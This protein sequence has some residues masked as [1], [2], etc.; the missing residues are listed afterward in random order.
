M[1]VRLGGGATFLRRRQNIFCLRVLFTSRGSAGALARRATL[2]N[3]HYALVPSIGRV[4]LGDSAHVMFAQATVD[5]PADVVSDLWQSIGSI[6]ETER[7]A[8][9][10]PVG[11]KLR[12][13]SH[14]GA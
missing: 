2:E 14:A 10:R 13:S 11:W 6:H 9:E 12:G 3:S 8:G 4:V 7:F 5:A 1:W